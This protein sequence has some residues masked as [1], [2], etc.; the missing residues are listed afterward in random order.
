MSSKDRSVIII[1]AGIAGLAAG[2]YARLNG[3]T[4]QI[5]E[6]HN[7]PGGMVTSWKRNGYL[8]DGCIEFLN[9]SNPESRMHALWEELGVAAKLSA[10]ENRNGQNFIDHNEMM[11]IRDVDGKEL[12]FY[13]DIDQFEKHL[14]QLAPIDTRIIHEL[15]TAIR[16]MAAFDPPLDVNPFE[17]V[18]ELPQMIRWMRTFNHYNHITVETFAE[19]FQ[20]PFLSKAFPAFM[21][22]GIPMGIALGSLAFQAQRNM[23]YPLGGSL[24][25]SQDIARRF[26]TL[27]GV[28]HYR[29]KVEEIWTESGPNG[30][31]ATG[32][33]L[34]DG[35]VFHADT[36]ISASDGF[37]ATFRL[38]KGKYT[39][40]E[41][42]NRY[43]HLPLTPSSVQVSLGIKRDF[44]SEPHSQIDLLKQP[45][46]FSGKSHKYL[47]YQHFSFDPNITVQGK[48]LIVSRI[49]SDYDYWKNLAVEPT[50]YEAEKLSVAEVLIHHLEKR[51]P[52]IS[53]DIEMIDVAT[54]LTFERYTGAHQGV[55]QSYALTPQTVAYS[56][57]G[58]NPKL[59][60]LNGFYQIG[61]WIQPGGGIFPAARSGREIIKRICKKDGRRFR[62]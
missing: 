24:A 62:T 8:I 27:G 26:S 55:Y 38:L 61:Q 46:Y 6:M 9:G 37:N 48:T 51:Y 41:I 1:G 40:N 52:G 22:P 25:F 4:A 54:P 58:M 13:P 44:S 45:L 36:V 14:L 28:I 3:Y 17:M 2:I 32:V 35:R 19:R 39:D 59:P 20:D 7:L 42:C 50:R 29:A 12:I 23:G 60:G 30:D 18:F 34:E 16:N 15:T 21:P 53:A 49:R 47:W 56:A 11:R 31:R 57:N 33:L 5:F 43:Q 10:K